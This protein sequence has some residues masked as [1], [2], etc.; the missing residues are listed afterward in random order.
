MKRIK[1]SLA[2]LFLIGWQ[3]LYAIDVRE[4]TS[5]Y[6]ANDTYFESQWNL[7]NEQTG[8]NYC[9]A[10][11]ITQ[12]RSDIKIAI[13]GDGIFENHSDFVVDECFS[14]DENNFY[15]IDC[16]YGPKG[17]KSA[18]IIKSGANNYSGICGIAPNCYLIS[19]AIKSPSCD[20]YA[21]GFQQ[22]LMYG[23]D[24]ILCAWETTESSSCFLLETEIGYALNNGRNGKG[25]VVVWPSGDSYYSSTLGEEAVKYPAKYNDGVLVVGAIKQNGIRP[26]VF[27]STANWSSGYGSELDIVAPG[28]DIPTTSYANQYGVDYGNYDLNYSSTFAAAAHVAAVAG[29]LL[30][31][32]PNLTRLEVNNIIERS[33]R[34]LS[35]YTFVPTS[36]RPNGTWNTEVGYGLLDAY[37][38]LQELSGIKYIQNVTY[39]SNSTIV[40]SKDTIIAG[41]S[42]T[43]TKPYGDVIVQA[44]SNVTFKAKRRIELRPGFR[45]NQGA[46]FKAIIESPSQAPSSPSNARRKD[47]TESDGYE[48]NNIQFGNSS[49]VLIP[50]PVNSILHVQTQE[51]LSQAKIYNLNGQCVLQ[52][53]QT[54]ID[55]SSLSQ[56]MYILCAVTSD[57]TSHQAKFIKE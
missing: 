35:N 56:G 45:A 42:V 3:L 4:G 7:N 24:V 52:S 9:Y 53:A 20:A 11:N 57:G 15:S 34:K 14:I 37:Q 51:N 33:A 26:S 48:T 22:A 36:N 21:A 46:T 38:A 54:D 29:L 43:S 40:E 18:G 12:G 31:V 41:Y 55:V 13:I 50:N 32:K 6:C 44:G 19:I 39:Q 23:A 8:I 25:T 16:L 5:S 49:L 30:S 1:C 10:K 47:V 27:N 17:T 28:N 2:L